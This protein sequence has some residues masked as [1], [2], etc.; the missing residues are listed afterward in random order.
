MYLISNKLNSAKKLRSSTLYK[1]VIS[2]E[3]MHVY[4]YV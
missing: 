1:L 3:I 2:I 4:M